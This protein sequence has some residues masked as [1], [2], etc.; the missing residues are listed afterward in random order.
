MKQRY[1]SE[2]QRRLPVVSGSVRDAGDAQVPLIAQVVRLLLHLLS[3]LPYDGLRFAERERL[4]R[5]LARISEGIAH[6]QTRLGQP[7]KTMRTIGSHRSR[8]V[9]RKAKRT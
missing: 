7:I 1:L 2:K 9:S 4:K 8:A 3:G 6:A 5:T